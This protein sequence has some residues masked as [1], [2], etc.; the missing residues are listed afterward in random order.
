MGNR[1]TYTLES[2]LESVDRAEHLADEQASAAG[3]SDDDRFKIMISVR[4]AAVN[5][6]LHGNAY[7]PDKSITVVYDT[8]PGHLAVSISDQG[9]GIQMEKLPDPL[10]EDNRLK[11]SGRGIFMI[12]SFMD[13][14][15]V[16]DVKPGTEITM[17]KHI[18][19]P[20]GKS[21]ASGKQGENK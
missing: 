8:E 20:A 15:Q 21:A 19:N 12:R 7:D 1:I 16:R 14:V 4:E 11:T 3:F 10:H 2:S 13:E 9:K 18:N 17:V 5:A 6:V